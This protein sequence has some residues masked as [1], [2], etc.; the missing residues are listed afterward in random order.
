MRSIF[1]LAA[2]LLSLACALPLA[3]QT[4]YSISPAEVSST[5]GTEVTVKGDFGAWPYGLIFGSEAVPATR[6]DE[7]TL[8]AITPPLLPGEYDVT[9]FEYDIGITTGIKLKVVGGF[10]PGFAQVLLPVFTPPVRGAFGSEFH[11][12]LRI[13]NTG[14]A[15]VNV[16]GLKIACAI[17]VCL[18]SARTVPFQ[19]RGLDELAPG[20]VE[21]DGNP[22]RVVVIKE[23]DL[24][25][26]A[27]NLRVHDVSRADLNFGTEIPIVRMDEFIQDQIVFTGV[28]TD[29]RFR[30]TLRIYSQ[31]MTDAIVKIGDREPVRL[32]MQPNTGI[33]DVPYVAYT[34]FPVGAGDVRVEITGEDHSLN[35]RLAEPEIFLWAMITVTNNETQVI[36]TITPQP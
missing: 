24:P 6:V 18:P 17:V 23:A 10:P 2:A 35:P 28:P 4:P 11:T 8:K 22:T 13:A 19:I 14:T 27:M 16:Y 36:S 3:A 34:D 9:V 7:H 20:D 5:G 30:N 12:D 25:Q 15:P 21:P 33:W 31:N 29:A 26:L 32:K 1:R